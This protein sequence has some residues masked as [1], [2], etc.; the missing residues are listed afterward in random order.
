[1]P[2]TGILSQTGSLNVLVAQVYDRNG[3]V[4]ATF[5]FSMQH[6]R[7]EVEVQAVKLYMET[8]KGTLHGADAAPSSVQLMEHEV[9]AKEPAP[10]S[11]DHGQFVKEIHGALAA[12]RQAVTNRFGH[13]NGEWW[14]VFNGKA[15]EAQNDLIEKSRFVP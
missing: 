2:Q 1:M 14:A 13:D 9:V 5:L 11:A 8:L 10:R 4:A 15:S 6:T 12:F 7:V 3:L